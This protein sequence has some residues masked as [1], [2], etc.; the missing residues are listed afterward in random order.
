MKLHLSA[1][2]GTVTITLV[3]T[4]FFTA[5]VFDS[6]ESE[7]EARLFDEHRNIT[8]VTRDD[9]IREIADRLVTIHLETV[10]TAEQ[11][12]AQSWLVQPMCTALL[13]REQMIWR[14]LEH[15]KHP[16]AALLHPESHTSM[17]QAALRC[18]SLYD[19]LTSAQGS[20]S[21]VTT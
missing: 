10:F 3:E 2:I 21:E 20:L 7:H 1:Q 16:R 5:T 12:R 8:G 17:A 18:R 14:E 15:A 13:E 9:T 4:V 19:A 6:A 11:I